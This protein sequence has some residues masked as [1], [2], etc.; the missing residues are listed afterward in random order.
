MPPKFDNA[1]FSKVMLRLSAFDHEE[2]KGER[3]KPQSQPCGCMSKT[4]NLYNM[5]L[6]YAKLNQM[7]LKNQMQNL[8][9]YQNISQ[10]EKIL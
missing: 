5:L 10:L 6:F 9:L 1:I 4:I 7:M 8:L 3:K 2:H